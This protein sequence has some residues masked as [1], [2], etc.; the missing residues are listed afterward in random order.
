M[1][2]GFDGYELVPVYSACK[3]GVH[4]LTKSYG[5]SKVKIIMKLYKNQCDI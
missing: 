1:L 4:G 3:H 2:T 5:V